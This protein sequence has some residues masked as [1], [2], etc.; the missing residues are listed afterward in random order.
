MRQTLTYCNI[1]LFVGLFF[2]SAIEKNI[3]SAVGWGA[4][5]T[6]ALLYILKKDENSN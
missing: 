1:I 2:L 3:S 4:A 5:T 6:Y